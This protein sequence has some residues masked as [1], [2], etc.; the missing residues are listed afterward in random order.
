MDILKAQLRILKARLKAQRNYS[1]NT[2]MQIQS[3]ITEVEIKEVEKIIDENYNLIE[4][5]GKRINLKDKV[6]SID[7][8]LRLKHEIGGKEF[9]EYINL[10]EDLE[11]ELFNKITQ[12]V[13]DSINKSMKDMF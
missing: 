10:T 5:L 13:S 11:S 9:I 4:L 6:L 3:D 12:A 1:L 7:L 8:K 2:D